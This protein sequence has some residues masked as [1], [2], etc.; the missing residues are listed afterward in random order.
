MS[1]DI[2]KIFTVIIKQYNNKIH[3]VLWPRDRR[4]LRIIGCVVTDGIIISCACTL[5]ILQQSEVSQVTR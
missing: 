2:N 4:R 3:D 5:Q 1:L